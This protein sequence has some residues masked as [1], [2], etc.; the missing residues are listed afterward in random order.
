MDVWCWVGT[1]MRQGWGPVTQP[2]DSS[3][4]I[5]SLLTYSQYHMTLRTD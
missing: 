4:L 3:K 5:S 2:R 1:G